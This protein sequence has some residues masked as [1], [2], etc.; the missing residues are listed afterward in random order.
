MDLKSI[1][2]SFHTAFYTNHTTLRLIRLHLF[3]FDVIRLILIE[4]IKI[5]LELLEL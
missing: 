4:Q 3:N 1:C 2:N 5:L